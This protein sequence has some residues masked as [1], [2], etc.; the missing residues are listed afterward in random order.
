MA[1]AGGNRF[2]NSVSNPLRLEG[3]ARF[4]E[5]PVEPGEVYSEN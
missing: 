4:S 5:I 3:D 2:R 1:E